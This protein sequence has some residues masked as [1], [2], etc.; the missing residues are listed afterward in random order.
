MESP[1]TLAQLDHIVIYVHDLEKSV[2]F[3][4]MLGGQ[5]DEHPGRSAMDDVQ[6][7]VRDP[8]GNQVELRMKKQPL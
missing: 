2:A 4:R 3:Y 5:V 1:F 6:F 7:R 8:D